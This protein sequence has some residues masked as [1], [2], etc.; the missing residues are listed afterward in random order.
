MTIESKRAGVRM[1]THLPGGRGARLASPIGHG[2]RGM[3]RTWL[4]G[5]GGGGGGGVKVVPEGGSCL[6]TRACTCR[7]QAPD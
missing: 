5:G 2:G 1:R 6:P 4:G 3:G 7:F